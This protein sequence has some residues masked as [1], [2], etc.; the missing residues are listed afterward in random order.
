MSAQYYGF[1]QHLE[2][3]IAAMRTLDAEIQELEEIYTASVATGQ[4]DKDLA[5]QLQ[6]RRARV[7]YYELGIERILF[8][9]KGL[10]ATFAVPTA[11]IAWPGATSQPQ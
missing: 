9:R 7:Q 4:E 11:T 8:A 10:T 5:R 2:R 3:Y 1:D 6:E